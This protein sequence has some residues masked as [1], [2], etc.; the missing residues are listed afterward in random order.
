MACKYA[1]DIYRNH[2][3]KHLNVDTNNIYEYSIKY[4]LIELD[5]YVSQFKIVKNKE[6]TNILMKYYDIKYS[7]DIVARFST[8]GHVY[9]NLNGV[10]TRGY[11]KYNLQ[12]KFQEYNI[13]NYIK[14]KF[15]IKIRFKYLIHDSNMI[16]LD[17]FCSDETF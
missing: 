14:N 10:Y 3:I 1:Y 17:E 16:G 9:A 8:S 2:I 4:Y 12:Y 11:N 7:N 13:I 5:L 15:D 6:L